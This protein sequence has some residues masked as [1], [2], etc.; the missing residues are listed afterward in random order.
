MRNAKKNN[1][2]NEYQKSIGDL[3]A[4]KYSQSKS[5]VP[6]KSKSKSGSR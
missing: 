3:L 2:V 4:V 1:A 5:N 6:L